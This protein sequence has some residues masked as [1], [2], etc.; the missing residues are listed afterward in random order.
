LVDKNQVKNNEPQKFSEIG[1]FDFTNL[2]E[3]LHSQLPKFFEK[4]K[5]QL[6]NL[7]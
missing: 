3:P 1:W 2:P 4:Y 5:K 7:K 6:S